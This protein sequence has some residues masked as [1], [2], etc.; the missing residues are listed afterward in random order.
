L[1]F[2]GL[3][4]P[5]SFTVC[6][7][8]RGPLTEPALRGAIDRLGRRHPLLAARLAPAKDGRGGCI[9]TE[10]VP[11]I[12]LRS[13]ERSADADWV[14]EIERENAQAFDYHSGPLMRCLWLRGADESDLIL[15]FDH[16]VVDGRGSMYALRDLM[17]LLADP[18]LRPDPLVPPL[19]RDLIPDAMRTK[20]LDRA[21]RY[22]GAPRAAAAAQFPA[23]QPEPMRTI[24]IEWSEAETAALLAAC[25]ARA[26]TVQA[27]L[28]AAF[29]IPFAED[30]PGTP[31]RFLE[32]PV[33]MRSR[34]S[35]P[36]GEAVGNYISLAVIR[37][38]CT[39]G[40]GPWEIARRAG[41]AIA[42]VTDEELFFDPIIMMAAAEHP[43]SLPPVTVRYDLSLSNVGKL[44]IPETYG[45]CRLLS[46]YGPTMGVYLSGHRILA[47]ATFGGRL[48]ATFTSRDPRAGR[49]VSRARELI[50]EMASMAEKETH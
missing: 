13:V 44:A 46:I 41:R 36:P 10:D 49:I 18:V 43:I 27:A 5:L 7:R 8:I 40:R 24:P 48:R 16:L 9:T 21:A 23:T 22:S 33:D 50:S 2:S 15:V 20:I 11:P 4:F 19:V 14:R 42:A 39:P 38:E 47:V 26:L 32:C 12:S 29:A 17:M 25:K 31:V 45:P 3:P 6:A 34:L 1:V 28:S 30:E 37:L 35:P